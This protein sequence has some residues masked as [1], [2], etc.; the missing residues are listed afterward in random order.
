[1]EN[2]AD[3]RYNTDKSKTASKRAFAKIYSLLLKT[4]GPQGWWPVC[5]G[6]G[7]APVYRPLFYGPH[8]DKACFEICAGAIL[9]QNTA[10]HN[11]RTALVSLNKAGNLASGAISRINLNVL[12]RLIRSSGFYRQK[13]M[14]L[15][16]FSL[17]LMSKHPEGLKKWFSLISLGELRSELLKIKGIGPET[18]DSMILY[19]GCR[20]KFVVDAYTHRVFGRLGLISGAYTELQTVFEE[21]LPRDHRIYNEYHAL[22]VAL[23]KDYCKKTKPVCVRCPLKTMCAAARAQKPECVGKRR[24]Q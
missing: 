20:P 24:K 21:A 19:A 5:V 4:F 13:A 22:I 10:W 8:P 15:K 12:G 17:Y 7:K 18:A 1:M 16:N 14:R 9:T 2:S 6:A 3:R 23:G 11:A